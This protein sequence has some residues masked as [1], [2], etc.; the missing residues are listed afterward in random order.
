MLEGVTLTPPPPSTEG[1]T[2]EDV[3]SDEGVTPDQSVTPTEDV[4]STPTVTLTPSPTLDD[5]SALET[6]LAPTPDSGAT[7]IASLNEPPSAQFEDV[8]AVTPPG[9]SPWLFVAIVLQITIIVGAG[10]MYVRG[11]KRR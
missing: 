10:Y 11:G 7:V 9:E 4:T 3:T 2:A 8:V 6:Q 1:V 5:V